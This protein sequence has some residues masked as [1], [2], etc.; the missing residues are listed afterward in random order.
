[1]RVCADPNYEP[2]TPNPFSLLYS[3]C[4]NF[5]NDHNHEEAEGGETQSQGEVLHVTY[6]NVQEEYVPIQPVGSVHVPRRRRLPDERQAITHKFEIDEQKGYMTVGL[7]EDGTPGEVFI[8]MNKEG[9]V[10]SGLVSSVA[11]ITSISLQYGV[12]LEALVNK[13][14]GMRF[15]PSGPTT[16]PDIP[17]AGSIVDYVFRWLGRKFLSEDRQRQLHIH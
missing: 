8:T 3:S 11:A 4:M 2:L 6:E 16:N 1:M 10:L 14:A 17:V 13:F 12:P 7:Y 9:S 5:T 15:E